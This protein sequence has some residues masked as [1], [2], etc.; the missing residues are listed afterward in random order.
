MEEVFEGLIAQSAALEQYV[1]SLDEAAFL[2][3]KV[4]DT[5][6]AKG[7]RPQYDFIQHCISHSAY[8]RGQIV[9][10]SHQLGITGAPITDY[11]AF[12]MFPG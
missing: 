3:E 10:M 6:W 2:Q 4:L 8:H 12:L 9:T 7:S 11:N 1:H 5:A